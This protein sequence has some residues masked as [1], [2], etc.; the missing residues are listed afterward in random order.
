MPW[1]RWLYDR[2]YRTGRSRHW[3]TGI[4]PP[5]VVEEIEREGAPAPGRALDLGC[6]TGTNALFLAAHGWEVVGVD[7]AA[8]AIEAA[9]RKAGSTDRVTFLQGDATRLSELGVEGPFELV[10]D[11]GCFHGI[12]AAGRRRYAMQTA[13]LTRSGALLMMFGFGARWRRLLGVPGLSAEGLR[14]CFGRDF[15]L[16][17]VLPGDEPAGAAWYYLRRR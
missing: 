8:Q 7:F 13:R 6:G 4:T 17:R 3:D 14:R 16:E 2:A 5:E 12:S 10:L 1:Q 11:V 9:R 15:D